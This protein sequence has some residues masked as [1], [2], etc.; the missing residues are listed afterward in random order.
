[1]KKIFLLIIALM[2]TDTIYAQS[3]LDVSAQIRAR[4]QMNN[5]DFNSDQATNNFSELRTRLSLK[6]SSIENVIGFVQLQDSRVMVQKVAHYLVLI[7]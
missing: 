2:I 6:F 7:I 1:M 5:K 3:G 4:Q